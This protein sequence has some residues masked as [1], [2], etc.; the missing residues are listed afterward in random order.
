MYFCYQFQEL[1]ITNQADEVRQLKSTQSTSTQT[2]G[3]ESGPKSPLDA[4]LSL[5]DSKPGD[6]TNTVI[7][8]ENS[9]IKP[10]PCLE[11]K[12]KENGSVS[13]SSLQE[14]S[15]EILPGEII[16]GIPAAQEVV[17]KSSQDETSTEQDGNSE[18]HVT[19][20]P[21]FP[22]SS[23][24]PSGGACHNVK[25]EKEQD[26]TLMSYILSDPDS[27][28]GNINS[29][30]KLKE[31]F[32]KE[33]KEVLVTAELQE[34]VAK[35][36]DENRKRKIVHFKSRFPAK[37]AKSKKP[38]TESPDIT[39]QLTL[40]KSTDTDSIA[41]KQENTEGVEI[42]KT[43]KGRGKGKE[44]R[45]CNLCL[46]DHADLHDHML[47]KHA[48]VNKGGFQCNLC[49]LVVYRNIFTFNEHLKSHSDTPHH[50]CTICGDGFKR[51]MQ[52]KTHLESC[53]Y[54]EVS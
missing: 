11:R 37:D 18:A 19:V 36:L 41:L 15:M 34:K 1:S 44:K 5:I 14:T 50:L 9:A 17:I 31:A 42:V 47:E 40:P 38:K 2:E 22:V 35:N 3:D 54:N 7:V 16:T 26:T 23:Q 10:Y 48:T 46:S 51:S 29:Q 28:T 21:K 45:M 24:S 39:F 30:K 53:H 4:V 49:D 25:N 27:S 52:L 13:V 20:V 8:N 33:L 6:V 12:R 43:K 32:Q